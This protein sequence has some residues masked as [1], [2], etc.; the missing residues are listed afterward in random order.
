M[1]DMECQRAK[2]NLLETE[3]FLLL[4]MPVPYFLCFRKTCRQTWTSEPILAHYSLFN[5]QPKPPYDAVIWLLLVAS[6]IL[7]F[8]CSVSQRRALT[9]S[10]A[11]A[12]SSVRV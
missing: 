2:M 7:S 9:L 12:Q 10:H 6:G 8:L 3:E 11:S 4:W 5:K 1:G